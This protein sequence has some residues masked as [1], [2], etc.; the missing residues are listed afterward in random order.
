MIMNVTFYEMTE[1]SPFPGSPV[2]SALARPHMRHI[3][4]SKRRK[5]AVSELP[6]STRRFSSRSIPVAGE[7]G[8]PLSPASV[9]LALRRIQGT[10]EGR[11]RMEVSWQA[12]SARE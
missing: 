6:L 7:T 3:G 2:G 10:F 4:P 11:L 5:A 8:K 1:I 12:L 9:D